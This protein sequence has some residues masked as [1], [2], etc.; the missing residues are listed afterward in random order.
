MTSFTNFV[1][2]L[3]ERS[4]LG[5]QKGEINNKYKQVQLFYVPYQTEDG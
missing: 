1:R 3:A 5:R 4:H 2:S